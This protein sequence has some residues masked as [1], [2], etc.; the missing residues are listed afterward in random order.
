MR[1][2]ARLVRIAIV[3]AVATL[4][5]AQLTQEVRAQAS[6][7]AWL[8]AYREPASRLI[9]AALADRTAWKR[10]AELTDT[11]GH[12]LGGSPGLEQA[13]GWAVDQMRGDGLDNVRA[14][15]V[16]VPHWVRGR[17]TLELV[18]PVTRP[19]VMLGLGGSVGTPPEGIT[20]NVVVV[21]SFDDLDARAADVAGKIVLYN[22]P[23]TDYGRTV[24]YRARGASRAARLGAVAALVRSVGPTG[25]RTPHTGSFSYEAEVAKI[26]AAAIS[27]EDAEQLQRMQ[28]RRQP[29]RARLIMEAKTLPDAD[30]ANVVAEIVGRERPEQV[31]VLGCHLDSWDVGTGAIDDG[32]GCIAAWEALRLMRATGL[33][34]RRT[35]RAVLFTNEENGLRGGQAYRDRHRAELAN[36]VLMIEADLGFFPP[37]AFG[38]SGS[39]AARSI[40]SQVAALLDGIDADR[41]GPSGGGADI[42]PSVEAGSIPAMSFNGDA[43]TYFM[44]H[45][46]PADTID[47]VDPMDLSRAVA[48]L[49]VMA[50]VVADMPQGLGDGARAGTR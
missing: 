33:R 4:R 34:P 14:E 45:H 3:M 24:Q 7:V 5:L 35:V 27:V 47:R 37:L 6:P 16:K 29:I 13:I 36:H 39:D 23:F 19:L 17:E 18:E 11:F 44:Y 46:T 41:V 28:D 30:S 22:V 10:L 25:L 48:A 26:P 42:G 2:R 15:P 40:V 1:L 21:S 12:R 20:A 49:G 38:F 31:V 43:Q 9:G 32:G 50:Y 8:D